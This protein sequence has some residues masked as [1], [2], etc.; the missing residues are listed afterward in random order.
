M[1]K[2]FF[3]IV[4]LF[5]CSV[6]ATELKAQ[7][8]PVVYK[9]WEMLIESNTLLDVSYRVIKCDATP[10]IHLLI[11]NENVFD[12]TAAFDL[13]ITDVASGQKFVKSINFSAKKTT[14]YKAL[15]DSDASLNALKF[16]LPSG[17]NPASLTVKITLKQ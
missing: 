10:Q 11:F 9:D 14:V 12:Q 15:C 1:K 6:A 4:C 3:F 2:L 5:A 17:Y 8:T 16:D 13:E 7:S